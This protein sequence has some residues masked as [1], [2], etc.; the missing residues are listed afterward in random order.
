MIQVFTED[1]YYIQ[2]Q[3][4]DFDTKSPS[5]IKDCKP[6]DIWFAKKKGKSIKTRLISRINKIFRDVKTGIQKQLSD[7]QQFLS[8][9][10]GRVQHYVPN[11]KTLVCKLIDGGELSKTEKIA[12]SNIS[13]YKGDIRHLFLFYNWDIVNEIENKYAIQTQDYNLV[14]VLK[15]HI[16][17]CKRR[18]RTYTGLIDQLY[19]N[20]RLAEVCGFVPNKIPTRTIISRAADKFCIEVFREITADMV[21]KCMSLGLIKG[22]MVGVDGTLIRSNTGPHKNKETKQ[23]TDPD[24]GLYV[25]GNYIKGIGFLAFKLTDIEYGLPMLVQCYKGSA[26]ENP[27]LR[28]ILTQFHETYGFYPQILST[29]KGMDSAAN[30]DF[31]NEFE[32]SA[33][34]Q[35]RDF[36]N[37][38]LIK[39]EKGKTFNPDY[40]KIIDPRVLERIANRRTESERQFSNDKWGYRRDRMS[41]RGKTEA[42]LY[43]LITMITT[44]LTAI[45][46]FSVGRSDLM[47]SSSAFKLLTKEG[48]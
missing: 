6:S 5:S 30:D 3:I 48:Q 34:I 22:R 29:D 43:M 42:E 23:Y 16:L 2:V 37:K 14:T 35:A 21:K 15:T 40:V 28:E 46:A 4:S 18:I 36:G 25:H 10:K 13:A 1:G 24:A 31:C 39:T 9:M 27:L 17:M 41:N 38:E 19:E 44:L 7:F 33:Y 32:I 45:T 8:E 12:Y 20:E 11:F 26:N 47:R